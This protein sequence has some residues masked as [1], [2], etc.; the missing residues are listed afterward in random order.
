[1]STSS[2]I[3]RILAQG[4]PEE[5]FQAGLSYM[6]SGNFADAALLLE[7]AAKRGHKE[8]KLDLSA[9]HKKTNSWSGADRNTAARLLEEFI[10][11]SNDSGL[12]LTAKIE[13]GILYCDVNR[14]TWAPDRG[15]KLIDEV[16]QSV[17][18]KNLP[19]SMIG[20]IAD[21]C[22]R[23]IPS[24]GGTD[25]PSADDLIMAI[26]YFNIAIDLAKSDG[27]Q[28]IAR[29]AHLWRESVEICVKRLIV[30]PKVEAGNTSGLD[31]EKTPTQIFEEIGLGEFA[32]IANEMKE[33]ELDI[34]EYI[35]TKLKE[36]GLDYIANRIEGEWENG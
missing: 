19:I 3:E 21:I 35:I 4:N 15:W 2:Q 12:L 33:K 36:H 9:L 28:I 18:I 20:D 11:E 7:E 13:L 24:G 23:G 31:F 30:K 1:M 16:I 29:L 22:F 17:G 34:Q 14:I 26:K 10:G 6:D 5:L 32:N 27:N 25:S 8:A